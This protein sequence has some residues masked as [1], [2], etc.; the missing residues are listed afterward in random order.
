LAF[1]VVQV[2]NHHTLTIAST[3]QAPVKVRAAHVKVS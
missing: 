1:Y 3:R 2:V